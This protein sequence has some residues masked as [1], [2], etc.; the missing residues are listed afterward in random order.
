MPDAYLTAD[1][2]YAIDRLSDA[3]LGDFISN[4]SAERKELALHVF[5]KIRSL[6][7][8]KVLLDESNEHIN[9]LEKVLEDNGIKIQ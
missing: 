2:I 6:N 5:A 3:T 9:N 7:V 1:E 8:S 4:L